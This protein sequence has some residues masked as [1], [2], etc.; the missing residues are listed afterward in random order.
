MLRN[1]AVFIWAE[2]TLFQVFVPESES[3]KN[4]EFLPWP[5]HSRPHILPHISE[6]GQPESHPPEEV[7]NSM[8]NEN[9]LSNVKTWGYL[10]LN[11]KHRW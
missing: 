4:S 11:E 10:R 9:F 6:S 7:K 2:S 5:Y 8:N 3:Q 1:I